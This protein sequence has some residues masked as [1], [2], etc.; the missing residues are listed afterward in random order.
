MKFRFSYSH[1]GFKAFDTCPRQFKFS[2]D[3]DTKD[4]GTKSPPMVIGNLAHEVFA[5]YQRKCETSGAAAPGVISEIAK[6]VIA[7]SKEE[8]GDHIESQV[9]WHCKQFARAM[10]FQLGQHPFIE[11]KVAFKLDGSNRW[12]ECAFM[13]G[14]PVFRGVLDRYF[15]HAGRGTEVTPEV[16]EITDWKT[17]RTVS[18]DADQLERYAWML[19]AKHPSLQEA[20]VREWYSQTSKF[21]KEKVVLKARA[22][23]VGNAILAKV[24]KIETVTDFFPNPGAHCQYCNWAHLCDAYKTLPAETIEQKAVA[25]VQAIAFVKGFEKILKDHVKKNGDLILKDVDTICTFVPKAPTRVVD[26]TGLVKVL[27]PELADS[28]LWNDIAPYLKVDNG[29]VESLIDDPTLG[30]AIRACTSYNSVS[31]SFK[32]KTLSGSDDDEPAKVQA[33]AVAVVAQATQEP[34]GLTQDA[35]KDSGKGPEPGT[36]QTLAIE[37]QGETPGLLEMVMNVADFEA[38]PGKAQTCAFCLDAKHH[39][40]SQKIAAIWQPCPKCGGKGMPHMAPDVPW[41]PDDVK[42]LKGAGLQKAPEAPP[43]PDEDAEKEAILE[44]KKEIGQALKKRGMKPATITAQ[45]LLVKLIGTYNTR[46]MTLQQCKHVVEF[47]TLSTEDVLKAAIE[48][49]KKKMME[50]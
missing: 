25:L 42:G 9:A 10:P 31:P 22:A 26:P 34:L 13:S 50:P 38:L 4:K 6:S 14:E 21:E 20:L 43:A 37:P 3:K 28:P 33:A 11:Q 41:S 47:L 2:K 24:M 44:A 48:E 46:K 32:I 29:A 7:E 8:L 12:V 35:G 39:F 15:F 17:G 49:G 36:Q 16:V 27:A 45:S 18:D 5:R 23:E 1:S 19:F 40:M 30:E